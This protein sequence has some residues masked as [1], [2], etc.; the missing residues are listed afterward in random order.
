MVISWLK[1]PQLNDWNTVIL[2]LVTEI[3]VLGLKFLVSGWQF[4]IRA[5]PR[6]SCDWQLK[7]V[8]SFT[9]HLS[10]KLRVWTQNSFVPLFFSSDYHHN[11][12]FI[13]WAM[14]TIKSPFSSYCQSKFMLLFLFFF[15]HLQDSSINDTNIHVR[16]SSSEPETKKNLTDDEISLIAQVKLVFYF[17]L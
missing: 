4:L 17:I 7:C 8:R 16:Y 6:A 14:I 15:F 5:N 9:A 12:Y 1:K 13:V 3:S 10:T 2:I 11:N